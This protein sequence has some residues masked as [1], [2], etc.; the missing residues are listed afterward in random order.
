MAHNSNSL[1]NKN[2]NSLN[3]SNNNNNHNN[4]NN[5]SNNNSSNNNNKTQDL[6]KRQKKK[7]TIYIPK[8]NFN[9]LYKNM[10]IVLNLTKSILSHTVTKLHVLLSLKTTI[11]L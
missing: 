3:N 7:L 8:K 9:K 1:S 6:S 10:T 2:N 4:S 5:N 11:K